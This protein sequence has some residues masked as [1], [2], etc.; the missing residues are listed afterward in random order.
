MSMRVV[1]T[2]RVGGGAAASKWAGFSEVEAGHDAGN[3]RWFV[4]R[5]LAGEARLRVLGWEKA[6]GKGWAQAAWG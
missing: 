4:R 5:H 1:P 3:A 6:V 2:G